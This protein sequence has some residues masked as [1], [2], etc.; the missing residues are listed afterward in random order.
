MGKFR[1]TITVITVIMLLLFFCIGC[2]KENG[3]VG[4]TD[5]SPTFSTPLIG[6]LTGGPLG[7]LA[8]NDMQYNGVVLA[9]N[10]YGTAFIYAAPERV[11][12]SEALMEGMIAKGAKIII[13]GANVAGVDPV[14]RL[15]RKYPTI[16]FVLLDIDAKEYLPNV[17]S[18]SF[19]SNEGSFLAGALAALMTNTGTIGAVGGVDLPVINLFIGGYREGAKYI[20][21]A[22]RV[23]SAYVGTFSDPIMPFAN[24]QKAFE[25]ALGMYTKNNADIIFQIAGGSGMGVFKAAKEAGR[26]AIGVDSDQDFLDQG[27]ILT[28]MM[29]RVD[30]GILIIIGK[31]VDGKWENRNF[32]IGLVEGGVSLSPM[33]YTSNLIGAEKLARIASITEL[34]KTG[35]LLVP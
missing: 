1:T 26:Y 17:A 22:I 9:Q 10:K 7:D 24:P 5:T 29:K 32:S 25:I 6:L 11:E 16:K 35:K 14:D 34:I 33:K 23:I 21:P 20:N 15:A 30:N 19:K 8:Y 4:K 18:I 12:Q 27:R 2:K 31:I 28:S 3:P 13:C